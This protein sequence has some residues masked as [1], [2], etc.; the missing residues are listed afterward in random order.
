MAE[1]MRVQR[2]RNAGHLPLALNNLLDT[3]CREWPEP[4]SLE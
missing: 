4:P 2:L 3:T 1:Q